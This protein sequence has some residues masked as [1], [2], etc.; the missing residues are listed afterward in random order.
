M[1]GFTLIL[2]SVCQCGMWLN[3]S[4][5]KCTVE[6]SQTN[7]NQSDYA[8]S[9]AGNLKRHLKIHSG[10]KPNKCNQCNYK[11]ILGPLC[12]FLASLGFSLPSL[13][14]LNAEWESTTLTTTLQ[15][16]DKTWEQSVHTAFPPKPSWSA[17]EPSLGW[18]KLKLSFYQQVGLPLVSEW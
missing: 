10:E 7:V 11:L 1:I 6:K 4:R 9:Q 14:P 2:L 17:V 8:S 5:R 12:Y 13:E 15:K 18:W 16:Q 3:S